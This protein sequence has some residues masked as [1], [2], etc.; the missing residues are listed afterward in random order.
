[1]AKYYF[2]I[3]CNTFTFYF[4][5]EIYIF[6][7][8]G[9]QILKFLQNIFRPVCIFW[10]NQPFGPFNFRPNLIRPKK[11]RPKTTLPI[12]YIYRKLGINSKPPNI[13]TKITGQ[14]FYSKNNGPE[15]QYFPEVS[16]PRA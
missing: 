14:S 10:P 2:T 6:T 12:F 9:H 16:A 8:N 3:A 1:M 4:M 15:C 13:L 11:F 5:L 7:K